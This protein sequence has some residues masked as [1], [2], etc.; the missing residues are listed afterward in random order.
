MGKPIDKYIY[1]YMTNCTNLL[2]I[3]NIVRH[4]PINHSINKSISTYISKEIATGINTR[5]HTY[6]YIYIQSGSNTM[7]N[8][9]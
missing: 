5:I 7:N 9:E 4:R 1:I 2:K 3:K 8:I 6:V